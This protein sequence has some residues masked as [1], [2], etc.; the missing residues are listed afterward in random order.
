MN[1]NQYPNKM[2]RIFPWV[3]LSL[4]LF[5]L[6]NLAM[7][8]TIDQDSNTG[9]MKKDFPEYV[10]ERPAPLNT[11]HAAPPAPTISA[12]ASMSITVDGIE[13]SGNTAFSETRLQAEAAS[14]LGRVLDE[15]DIEELRYRLTRLY[16]DQGYIN[17]G[18]VLEGHDEN[19][20]HLRFRLVEGRLK[21]TQV[22]ASPGLDPDYV[23]R[24]LQLAGGPPFHLP[25][26]QE[27][28]LLLLEDPLIESLHGDLLPGTTPGEAILQ[29]GA[30]ERRRY[31][32][33]L[34][35]DN[36]GPV[37]LGEGRA[38]LTGTYRNFTGRGETTSFGYDLGDGNRRGRADFNIPI[39]ARD[40]RFH[41]DFE[42]G[43]AQVVEKPAN[44]LDINSDY[45]AYEIGVTH[46][47]IQH[48]KDSLVL[49]LSIGGRSNSTRLLGRPFSLTQGSVNGRVKVAPE[50]F[51]QEW[52]ARDVDRMY[53]LRSAISVGTRALGATDI[54]TGP[55]DTKF[56]TWVLQQRYSRQWLNNRLQFIG[57][58]DMQFA[59]SPLPVL[60]QLGIGGADTVRGYRENVLIRDQ[61]L[62]ASL[63]ARYGLLENETQVRY[64][65]LDGAVFA[66][67][68]RGWNKGAGADSA[69]DYLYSAGLG[70]IWS[71]R[72]KLRAE[73]YWGHAL[74]D[75]PQKT[76][77]TWQD[78]G[79]HLQLRATY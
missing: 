9:A 75:P 1:I 47:F 31:G 12:P 54:H 30:T 46:P 34:T 21:E 27:R 59:D 49:G 69:A 61:A 17:S 44:I 42:R 51:T 52:I 62:L 25:T 40:T 39:S 36:H 45:T 28:F 10:Q 6:S 76:G 26:L 50:R 53:A 56:V 71:W 77:G 4:F 23:A 19:T 35:L 73:L 15:A 58:L 8:A 5:F 70:L 32:F 18:A 29:A 41:A 68:A 24:R 2:N 16:V 20:R 37:S 66:D 57:R 60:E 38:L 11:P 43:R 13:F 67:F 55:T 78:S 79:V 48:L 14:F 33:G 22:K 63:E 7:A 74:K 3:G 72:D 65:K 64:G